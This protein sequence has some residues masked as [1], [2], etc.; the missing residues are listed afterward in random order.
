MHHAKMEGTFSHLPANARDTLDAYFQ[1]LG[2]A[3]PP[4]SD[5]QPPPLPPFEHIDQSPATPSTLLTEL[6]LRK[7][8]EDRDITP[9]LERACSSPSSY[10]MS[11]NNE[12][13]R[14]RVSYNNPVYPDLLAERGVVRSSKLPE[15]WEDLQATLRAERPELQAPSR[16]DSERL[17]ALLQA[18]ANETTFVSA[19]V[20][21]LIGLEDILLDECLDAVCKAQWKDNQLQSQIATLTKLARPKP[22]VTV[23]FKFNP[24]EC[25]AGIEVLE[26]SN[27]VLCRPQ[28]V[29]PCFTLEAKGLD[30]DINATL[31]NLHNGAV[32]LRNLR[33]LR[34][35]TTPDSNWSQGFDN[36]TC[37][38]TANLTKEKAGI[39][40]HWTRTAEDGTV[41]YHSIL[42]KEWKVGVDS[43]PDITVYMRNAL[44]FVKSRV[45][46]WIMRDLQTVSSRIALQMVPRMRERIPLPAAVEL[47]GQAANP[48]ASQPQHSVRR[49][50]RTRTDRTQTDESPKTL[51]SPTKRRRH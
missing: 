28:L 3:S 39:L 50:T 26:S 34:G 23:G 21:H 48:S 4:V 49:S 47:T 6:N 35:K 27:P 15:N 25:R 20:N 40:A 10:E 9:P 36:R 45:R 32:M 24:M 5:D 44:F 37:V 19:V 8:L 11:K 17:Q 7:F 22:D 43:W 2:E 29:Y 13:T 51:E 12:D 14:S 33:E 42:A 41:E 46:P 38:L 30:S 16:Y 31:Q 18:S 1:S